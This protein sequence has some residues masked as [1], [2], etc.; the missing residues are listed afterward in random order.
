MHCEQHYVRS[1]GLI[2]PD[3]KRN[4]PVVFGEEYVS[5]S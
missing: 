4:T 5:C 3:K 2:Q 1:T